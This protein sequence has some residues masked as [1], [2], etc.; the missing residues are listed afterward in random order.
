MATAELDRADASA[1]CLGKIADR[2]SAQGHSEPFG[3]GESGR[4]QQTQRMT[5]V[6]SEHLADVP[7]ITVSLGKRL[8]H[9]EAIMLA[10][11]PLGDLT[12]IR[13]AALAA[14][15]AVASPANDEEAGWTPHVTLCYSTA[16]P[17][18]TALGKELPERQISIDAVSLVIQDGPERAWKW[19]TVGTVR[20][21]A[22]ALS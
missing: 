2:G 18:I 10:V 5:E 20:L 19:T 9:P 11:T 8:Y 13:A 22:T 15:K 3:A 16:Q 21:H 1:G 17:I 12:P 7:P 4:D 14:T 6:A